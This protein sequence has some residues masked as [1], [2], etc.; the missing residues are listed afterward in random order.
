MKGLVEL[1]F[2]KDVYVFEEDLTDQT[3]FLTDTN[4]T[5]PWVQVQLDH[6][7]DSNVAML[8]FNHTV[9][10]VDNRTINIKLE[11]EHANHVSL[12]QI[13]DKIDVTLWGPFISVDEHALLE[14]DS[15][16]LNKPIPP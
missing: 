1:S 11:F 14:I 9:T 6:S 3:V 4:I 7:E 13:E 15:R 12:H 8:G 10:H 5:L 16:R 2:S